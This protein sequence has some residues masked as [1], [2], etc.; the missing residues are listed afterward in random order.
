MECVLFLSMEKRGPAHL[1]DMVDSEATFV[2]IR[3]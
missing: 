3:G 1:L 2:R